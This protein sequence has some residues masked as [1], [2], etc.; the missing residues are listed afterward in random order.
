MLLLL[1]VGVG[2]PELIPQT[3]IVLCTPKR[4]SPPCIWGGVTSRVE[5]QNAFLADSSL[6]KVQNPREDH[7]PVPDYLMTHSSSVHDNPQRRNRSGQD[8]PLRT[9][10]QQGPLCIKLATCRRTRCGPTGTSIGPPAH[11][12]V[13]VGTRLS[14][15]VGGLVTLPTSKRPGA[16]Q[17]SAAA[18]TPG[19]AERAGVEPRQAKPLG[20]AGGCLAWEQAGVVPAK[21]T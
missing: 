14:Y 13:A 2:R 7:F 15:V 12:F 19:K 9:R 3:F 20:S 6:C 18:R 10:L 4:N 21:A 17:P 16:T 11:S 5:P 1:A 8:N